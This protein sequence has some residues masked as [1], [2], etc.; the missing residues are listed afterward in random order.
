M[1]SDPIADLK[2]LAELRARVSIDQILSRLDKP[3]AEYIEAAANLDHAAVLARLRELET[4]VNRLNQM[5]RDTGYGQGAIDA[6]AAQ[7]ERLESLEAENQRLR[8]ENA[9]LMDSLQQR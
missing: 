9:F 2:R 3:T 4:D 7:C 1:P 6:Y 8:E 5:L